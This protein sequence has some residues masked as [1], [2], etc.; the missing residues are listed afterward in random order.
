M[1]A[2]MTLTL[3]DGILMAGISWL[4]VLFVWL[5]RRF[6]RSYDD[7]TKMLTCINA[8]ITAMD[9]KL[10]AATSVDREILVALAQQNNPLLRAKS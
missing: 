8:T 6:I 9:R 7:N 10:D 4:S 3:L 1:K 2:L 5:L